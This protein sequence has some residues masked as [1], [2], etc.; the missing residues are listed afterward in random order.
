MIHDFESIQF[1]N[2]FEVTLVLEKSRPWSFFEILHCN[3]MYWHHLKEWF[4]S[5]VSLIKTVIQESVEFYQKTYIMNQNT[6]SLKPNGWS[7]PWSKELCAL[8]WFCSLFYF[9]LLLSWWCYLEYMFVEKIDLRHSTSKLQ[10]WFCS[11][12]NKEQYV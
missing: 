4:S 2:H 9:F 1:V 10:S 3:S 11:L 5:T 8:P 7:V 12:V 6:D